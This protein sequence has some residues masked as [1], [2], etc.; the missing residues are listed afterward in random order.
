VFAGFGVLRLGG[1]DK[2]QEFMDLEA[3]WDFGQE[4]FELR[5]GFGEAAGVVLRDGGLE[6]AVEFGARFLLGLR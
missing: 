5:G 2:A 4:L 3:V 6:G 1:V